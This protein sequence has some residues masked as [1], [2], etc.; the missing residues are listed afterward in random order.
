MEAV[1][2][3]DGEVYQPGFATRILCLSF[4]GEMICF[5]LLKLWGFQIPLN[6]SHSWLCFP[7]EQEH[8]EEAMG[9]GQLHVSMSSLC[10]GS[11]VSFSNSL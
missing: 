9:W 1:V 8:P 10:L 5:L 3:E 4:T 11:H 6:Y 7:R 2:G